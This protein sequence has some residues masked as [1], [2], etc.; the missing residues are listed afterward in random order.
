MGRRFAAVLAVA[1]LVTGCVGPRKATGGP[2]SSVRLD[3][4]SEVAWEPDGPFPLKISIFNATRMMLFMVKPRPEATEV[5]VYRADGQVACRTA[6]PVYEEVEGWFVMKVK[7]LSSQE[8]TLDLGHECRGIAS[9]VYRYEV[10]FLAQNA[11]NVTDH[12]W[13]GSL[14]PQGG[15]LLVREGASKLKYADLL[16]ALDGKELPPPAP[17]S[18]TGATTDPATTPA[19]TG[20]ANAVRACVDKELA[21]RGLN[22]YGDAVGTTY[23][24]GPPTDEYGRVLYVASRNVAIRKACGISGF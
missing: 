1:F 10:N 17:V 12:V 11:M 9:G 16:A 20:D 7:S 3:V 8:L 24:S 13:S 6:R 4:P 18:A 21:D 23:A 15:R 14:G 19:A 5:I 22:A 2:G